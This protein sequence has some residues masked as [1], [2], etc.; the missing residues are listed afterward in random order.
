[1]RKVL[2]PPLSAEDQ[3]SSH[4]SV[5][6]DGKRRERPDKGVADE[7]DLTVVLDPAVR[8]QHGD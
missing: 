5:E 6:E 2:V 4:G 3:Q 7:V 1:M 8:A